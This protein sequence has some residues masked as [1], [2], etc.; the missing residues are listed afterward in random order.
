LRFFT[1]TSL[2]NSGAKPLVRA[3]LPT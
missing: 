3:A 2:L 1:A